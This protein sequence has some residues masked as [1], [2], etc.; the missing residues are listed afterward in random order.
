MSEPAPGGQLWDLLRGALGTR[1]LAHRRRP[2]RRR[3]ARRTGRARSTSS[4]RRSAPTRTR[5]T[6]S[7]ARSRATASS[8][9]TS[10]ASSA[11]P[12]ASELL[13][14]GGW[15]DFAHLFGGVWYQ[16]AAS[17]DATGEPAFPRRSARD[18]WSWLG[19]APDE[20][21]R[22]R[23]RDGA[24]QGAARRAVRRARLARRRDGRRRRRRQRLA[25]RRALAAAAGPA[26]DRLR[27]AR[28]PC[29]TRPRS[30]TA[31]SSSPGSFFERVPEGDVYVL[32]T[33][34]HDWDDESATAIL[35]TIRAAAPPSRG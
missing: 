16:A 26:R 19:R 14:G 33:I 31:S 3:R 10:P 17:L 34:L 4:R 15:G 24:G 32:S 35:Q 30:A 8:P 9:R 1:A 18:F 27:P 2:R 13:R 21:A 5:S 12:T 23:P 20:R 7:C 29:A 25:A 28:R 6:G 22:V 11:T